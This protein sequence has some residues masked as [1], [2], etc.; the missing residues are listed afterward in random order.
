MNKNKKNIENNMSNK[1]KI[2]PFNDN[3]KAY[4]D[5]IEFSGI[6]LSQYPKEEEWYKTLEN[7]LN[8]FK[9]SNPIKVKFEKTDVMHPKDYEYI[10]N[11][12]IALYNQ[13]N[14]IKMKLTRQGKNSKKI[15]NGKVVNYKANFFVEFPERKSYHAYEISVEIERDATQNKSFK[16]D[17]NI[18]NCKFEGAI[19]LSDI[20][21]GVPNDINNNNK[22]NIRFYKDT[23]KYGEYLFMYSEPEIKSILAK[24]Q[25]QLKQIDE[26]DKTGV[27]QVPVSTNRNIYSNRFQRHKPPKEMKFVSKK[28]YTNPSK[29]QGKLQIGN[30]CMSV[31]TF[32]KIVPRDCTETDVE[33]IYKNNNLKYKNKCLSFHSDGNIEFLNCDNLSSCKPN[34]DLNNCLNFKFIKY[35]GLEIDG[36][37]SCLN[38]NKNTWIG[39]TCEMSAKA[40]II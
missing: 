3:Q 32:G 9:K 35:G 7:N 34:T 13:N 16:F 12:F 17:N 33:F 26:I 25:G 14:T 36:N 39:E 19:G 38:P 29:M 15:V 2:P 23:N 28:L 1:I 20:Q 4:N 27:R 22:N 5:D 37:N 6:K 8:R 24:K 30:K 10:V 18:V 11:N 40:D 21:F 31:D